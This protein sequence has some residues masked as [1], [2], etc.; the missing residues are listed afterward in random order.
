M[1]DLEVGFMQADTS[2]RK[3][4]ALWKGCPLQAIRD[5]EKSGI[6]IDDDFDSFFP[7]A[8]KYVI[9]GASATAAPVLA[10]CG[11]EV[12][13]TCN[14]AGNGEAYLGDAIKLGAFGQVIT[15]SPNQLWYE[16]RVK[17]SDIVNGVVFAGLARSTDIAA[18]AWAD[19]TL[20]PAT[21]LKA[22]GFRTLLATPARL[23]VFYMNAAAATVYA[24]G[25]ATLV[26]GTYVKLGIRFD[27]QFGKNL[28]HFYVNGVEIAQDTTG[29]LGIACNATNFPNGIG[30]TP[31]W[32][33]KSNAS[34]A[35][36]MTIDW[37][38]GAMV[39]DD[40]TFG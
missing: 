32:G 38:F 26:V 9:S 36:A 27:A 16:T 10:Q 6:I 17:V 21:T 39:I 29:A 37:K 24:T 22:F 20:V 23:D 25:A 19:T 34:A 3:S 13:L 33:T 28:V 2:R 12:V 5:R 30:L 40:T 1:P 8:S 31:F 15:N 14:A 4:A 18:A 35:I 7:T 11:G